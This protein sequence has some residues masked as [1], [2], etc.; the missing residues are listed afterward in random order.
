MTD[1]RQAALLL[2]LM[3]VTAVFATSRPTIAYPPENLQG[4]RSEPSRVLSSTSPNDIVHPLNA[5]CPPAQV[6]P[7]ITPTPTEPPP[8]FREWNRYADFPDNSGTYRSAGTTDGRYHY[9]CGG[10][11]GTSGAGGPFNNLW[12]YDP[13]TDAWTELATMPKAVSNH[14][15]IAHPGKK[16]L[17]VPGGYDLSG[18]TNMMMEYDITSDEWSNKSPCPVLDFGP[19]GAPYG[20]SILVVWGV[21]NPGKT[22]CYSIPDDAWSERASAPG[23]TSHG[24]MARAGDGKLYYAGGWIQQ[25]TFICYDPSNGSWST[26]PSMSVGRHGLGLCAVGPFVLAYGGAQA[27]TPGAWV[28]CYDI[29]QGSWTTEADMPYTL[30]G[31]SF[32]GSGCMGRAYYTSGVYASPPAV[33]IGGMVT[34]PDDVGVTEVLVPS[35]PMIQPGVGMTPSVKVKNMGLNPE[36]SF[37]VMFRVDSAGT[38]VY[39]DGVIVDSIL[40]DEELELTFT[41]EWVPNPELWN[42]YTYYTYTYLD[43][44]MLPMNDTMRGCAIYAAETIYSNRTGAPPSIDGYMAPNEWT[45]VGYY[46]N[47]SNAGGQGGKPFG[48]Y[49]AMAWFM[50]DDNFLY[51]AY[52]LPEALTRDVNDQIGFYCDENDDGQWD[53]AN[54]EGNFWYLINASLGDEVRYRPIRPTGPGASGI[55]PG[56]QSASGVFNGYL[57]FE[58]KTPFGSYPY[59]LNL[60]P[61]NDTCGVFIYGLDNGRW[62]GWWPQDLPFDS[63]SKPYLYGTL[64]LQTSQFGDVGVKSIDQPRRAQP[65]VMFT[66]KAT[67]KNYGTT[68]MAFTAYYFIEDPDGNRFYSKSENRALNPNA[69]VQISFP[70]TMV[71]I[72]GTYTVICSTA[73]AG[74]INP[75]NDVKTGS[76]DC[77]TGPPVPPGWAEMKQVPGLVKDGGWL[78]MNEENGLLYAARGYKSG[79]F[80]SYDAN[81]ESLGRWTTLAAWPLGSEGKP[82]AKGA[83]G[84]YGG[85]YVWAVKGSNTPGFWKYSIADD[86]WTQLENIPLG[87]SGKNPKGGTDVVYVVLNDTGYVYLLK[88]YKQDFMRFN[89]LTGAWQ[90]LPDAPAGAKPKWDK[91]SWLVYDGDHTIYAHKAKYHEF[92]TYDLTTQQWSTTPLQGMPFASMQTGKNKK[93]KDGGDGAYYQGFIYA[94][95]GGNTCEFYRYSIAL[96]AWTE[97]APMPE[98]G[99]TGKKKRVK[100]GGA[101]AAFGDAW[102]FFAFKGGKTNEFWRY[103]D[104]AP[105][106]LAYQPKRSGVMGAGL[107][108]SRFGFNIAPN[109]VVK[110]YGLLSYSLPQQ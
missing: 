35:S 61:A 51:A 11:I 26:L 2:I 31:S 24:S 66:P 87:T 8:T 102:M 68:P 70:D 81:A 59:Q 41:N 43:G 14:C 16:K 36:Y 21:Y 49:T 95:K 40:P 55:A 48:P 46:M 15:V 67:W 42:G 7:S 104:S 18:G 10:W 1:K 71:E 12:R 9:V 99:S 91:G 107:A 4:V 103:V 76:F 65:E 73:A 105:G 6:S 98:F 32:Q 44:D 74:D 19:A 80:Y 13:V 45:T 109:P 64:I 17:Y 69:E 97:L 62:M 5:V 108:V 75:G 90:Q 34:P 57:V 20:D 38:L 78:A 37:P 50:H 60:N 85:G 89:T 63:F 58:T 33:H 83:A 88:G 94:L 23:V 110:G 29:T 93:S 56:S 47:F 22:Y 39:E 82:P 96:S 27:W 77:T 28:A 92:W 3:L 84:C 30:G 72:E 101:L 25:T 86:Q 54:M 100:Q 53:N 79:D 106:L 52:A